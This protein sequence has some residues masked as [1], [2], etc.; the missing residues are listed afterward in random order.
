MISDLRFVFFSN[1]EPKVKKRQARFFSSPSDYFG[2][3]SPV[4]LS[5]FVRVFVRGSR[6][7]DF[8]GLFLH[9]ITDF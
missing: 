5:F 7:A 8:V 4:F 2:F 3:F 9:Y 1:L 6:K